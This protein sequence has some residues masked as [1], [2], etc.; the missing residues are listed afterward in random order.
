MSKIKKT[1]FEMILRIRVTRTL[2]HV[3]ETVKEY[4]NP[5]RTGVRGVLKKPK[6]Y[7][8]TEPFHTLMYPVPTEK[9]KENIRA[10]K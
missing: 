1:D 10:T 4:N 7:P 5:G 8:M 9:G 2:T 6:T 3:W